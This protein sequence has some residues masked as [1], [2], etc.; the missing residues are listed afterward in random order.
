MQGCGAD[1]MQRPLEGNPGSDDDAGRFRWIGGRGLTGRWPISPLRSG[2]GGYRSGG[3]DRGYLELEGD[4][5]T[6]QDAAGLEGGV[7]G[8]AVVLAVD[9]RGAFEPDPQVAERVDSCAALELKL[10][11]R[12]RSAEAASKGAAGW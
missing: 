8:D 12:E 4:L 10:V 11:R 3:F 5:V 2:L 1:R 6:D 7:P 9:D